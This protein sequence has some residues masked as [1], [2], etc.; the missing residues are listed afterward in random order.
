MGA[1]LF[2]QSQFVLKGKIE[3][4][5]TG[6]ISI[7][8][9]TF[10]KDDNKWTRIHD[11]VAVKN[12]VFLF[13]GNIREPL[14]AW[15]DY[16]S[17]FTTLFIEP[18]NMELYLPKDNIEK[19]KLQGS[20]IQDDVELLRSCSKESEDL[21]TTLDDQL[22]PIREQLD[23]LKET[24]PDYKKLSDK[25]EYLERQI[26]SIRKLLAQKEIQFIR[27]NPNSFLPV[28]YFSIQRLY[29]Q[30][31]LS[32][33]STRVLFNNLSEQV[34]LSSLGMETNKYIQLLEHVRVGKTAPDFNTP[35]MNGKMVRLSD[36][37]GKSYVLLDFWA[38][39]CGPCLRG[40]PHLKKVYAKYHEKGFEIVG[41]SVDRKKDEWLT[42]IKK[43][44]I[45][46]WY[47]VSS[48]Q[49]MEKRWQGYMND[50]DI[51]EKYPVDPIP[52][53]VLIN[54]AGT[55]IGTWESYSEENEK[56][57]DA[58]LKEVFGE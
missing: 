16:N 1:Q 56:D 52:R 3:G 9:A 55:I 39:Y 40:V 7:S 51:N 11:T 27:S 6:K 42:A 28:V 21:W 36:F 33:D 43:H 10:G 48:A 5:L 22:K 17:K 4:K 38:S 58:K 54:K 50:E 18:S 49:D 13:H 12:G 15:L 14:M 35:D 31:Y 53:Y 29:T 24:H 34:R 44:D 57:Q 30:G 37:R 46:N 19:F 20:K 41:V 25:K 8:Y 45:S 2:S 23:T 32:L 47:Q 26:D